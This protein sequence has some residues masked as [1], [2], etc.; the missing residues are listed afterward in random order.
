M[1]EMEFAENETPFFFPRSVSVLVF[2]T[3]L[4]DGL[5]FFFRFSSAQIPSM[6]WN[7]SC[8]MLFWPQ[9][10]K[11]RLEERSCLNGC[12]VWPK[13][14]HL[15]FLK[16]ASHLFL[17]LSFSPAL[18]PCLF[19]PDYISLRPKDNNPPSIACTFW[20]SIAGKNVLRHDEIH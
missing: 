19:L 18:L 3:A 1:R 14:S 6:A 9:E 13:K 12:T 16:W 11:E 20:N 7:T 10:K 5:D 8:S 15:L 4:V 2:I 17:S